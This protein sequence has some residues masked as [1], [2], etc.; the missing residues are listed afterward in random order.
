MSWVLN[1]WV[2]MAAMGY[3]AV[4]IVQVGLEG[5]KLFGWFILGVIVG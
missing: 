2:S 1:V 3:D 5:L 4:N